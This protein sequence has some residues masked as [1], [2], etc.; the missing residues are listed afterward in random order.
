MA[1]PSPLSDVTDVVEFD[2]RQ[3]VGRVPFGMLASTCLLVLASVSITFLA[4][5]ISGVTSRAAESAQD[6]SIYRY[7]VLGDNA[8]NPTRHKNQKDRY[9]NEQDSFEVRRGPIKDPAPAVETAPQEQPKS[10]PTESEA[11]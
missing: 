5:P 8:D 3:D 6:D 1:H 10:Q 9:T 11:K 2:E 4:G 7:A